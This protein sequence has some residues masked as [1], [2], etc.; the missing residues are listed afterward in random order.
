MLL[1]APPGTNPLDGFK[2]VGNV[3]KPTDMTT[4][5]LYQGLQHVLNDSRRLFA[6]K[7]AAIAEDGEIGPATTHLAQL[8]NDVWD[9]PTVMFGETRQ[10]AA[11]LFPFIESPQTLAIN[12]QLV[13]VELADRLGTTPD[14]TPKPA[15]RPSTEQSQPL[16]PGDPLPTLAPRSKRKMGVGTMILVGLLGLAT[17]GTIVWFVRR[18]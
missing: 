8:I 16:P 12:A 17:L 15:K 9:D 6:Q 11:F 5:G 3:V 7:P 2:V 14:F 4:L 10:S 18:K 1:L 13:A